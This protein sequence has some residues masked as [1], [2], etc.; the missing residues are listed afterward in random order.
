MATSWGTRLMAVQLRSGPSDRWARLF[1]VRAVCAPFARVLKRHVYYVT[2]GFTIG[3]ASAPTV[4]LHIDNRSSSSYLFLAVSLSCP[5]AQDAT[6]N[7]EQR[8]IAS[9]MLDRN[10]RQTTWRT[11]K[12]FSTP[13]HN[14]LC[15]TCSVFIGCQT[16]SPCTASAL[17]LGMALFDVG[18]SAPSAFCVARSSQSR[19]SG[20]QSPRRSSSC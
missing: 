10:D 19:S 12:T 7:L 4:Q 6:L 11:N 16:L 2:F 14:L 13:I 18:L 17:L 20:R 8:F 3:F 5:K 1:S 15:C 9:C